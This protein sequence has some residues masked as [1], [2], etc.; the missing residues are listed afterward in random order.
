[1]NVTWRRKLVVFIEERS[2][3]ENEENLNVIFN[4]FCIFDNIIFMQS[5]K[6]STTV[7]VEAIR[8]Y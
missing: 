1:M 7:F 3:S 6:I 2:I 4:S 5:F 8:K